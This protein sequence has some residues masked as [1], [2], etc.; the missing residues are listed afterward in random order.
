MNQM[1][2]TNYPHLLP[3]DAQLWNDYLSLYSPPHTTFMYDVAVGPGRDPGDNY[4]ESIRN[5]A[6]QL[7]K[8][9][10]D[11]VGIRPDGVDIFEL[12]QSA[13]LKAAGQAIVYPHLL[14][15]TWSLTLPVTTTIICRNCQDDIQPVLLA[16]NVRLVIIPVIPNA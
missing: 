12:T 1:K 9:R 8:R 4:D 2:R 15:V 3:E 13:G 10:I 5:M 16:H 7:S 14:T 11:V 6:L